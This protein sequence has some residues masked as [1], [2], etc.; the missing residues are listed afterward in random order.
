MLIAF[1]AALTALGIFGIGV[2][3]SVGPRDSR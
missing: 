2:A 3:D 1:A